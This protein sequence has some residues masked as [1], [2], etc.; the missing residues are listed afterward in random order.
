[1]A[2]AN[3]TAILEILLA[4]V[5]GFLLLAS[6]VMALNVVGR[7]PIFGLRTPRTLSSDREWVR[8]NRIGG[9]V[10]GAFS[11]L[12]FGLL[13]LRVAGVV[14]LSVHG[15]EASFLAGLVGSAIL[16]VV[17]GGGWRAPREG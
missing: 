5:N 9:F 4:G 14:S 1:M 3:E 2:P 16:A 7:N 10:L 12:F 6:I 13:L 17:L 8:G 15:L 11:L